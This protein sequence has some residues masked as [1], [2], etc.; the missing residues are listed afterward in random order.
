MISGVDMTNVTHKHLPRTASSVRPGLGIPFMAIASLTVPAVDGIAKLL[1]AT[2]SPFFVAWS[3]YFAA[4]I[5]VLILTVGWYRSPNSLRHDFAS[6]ALRT[7]LAVGAMTCFFF[8][9]TEIPLATAFGGY[10][11]GPV[12][13]AMLVTPVLRERL[14]AWRLSA[15]GAGL[16]GAY[17][18]VKP[19][20]DLRFGSVLAVISGALFAGYLI[21]TRITASSTSPIDA[22]RFQCV[23]A[24]LLL[25]PFA[26]SYWSWPNNE[27][28][29]LI[30]MMG[31][32]SAVCHFMVI[33]AFRYAE[34][35][36]L[37]PLTYLELVTAVLFGHVV[38]SEMP[39]RM[40]IVGI[41]LI[42]VAGLVISLTER[43]GERNV[44]VG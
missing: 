33:A 3:R 17:L 19:G 23:F 8:A 31:A 32:I 39:D 7:I 1:G 18:I 42:V 5:A 12:I 30:A 25:T 2:H 37:S 44:K 43:R 27:E 24:A 20:L 11:L 28:L 6:N 16:I 22:L 21:T 34:A 40:A 29:L 38:F 36:V 41:A 14:T 10:F 4:S 35:A 13:A 26:V 9:I 15:V